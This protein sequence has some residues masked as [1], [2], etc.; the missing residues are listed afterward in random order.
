MAGLWQLQL[1]VV[2]SDAP[3]VPDLVGKVGLPGA[4]GRGKT[5]SPWVQGAREA[6][7]E[8]LGGEKTLVVTYVLFVSP[9]PRL[10]RGA[11]MESKQGEYRPFSPHSSFPLQLSAPPPPP[12]SV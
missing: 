10:S 5:R 6:L 8:D 12:R 4:K 3:L 1:L 7:G 2:G 11:R 9:L